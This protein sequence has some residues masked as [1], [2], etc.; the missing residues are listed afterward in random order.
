[1]RLDSG[2]NLLVGTTSTPTV[3]ISATS[4]G[5]IALDPDSYSAWNRE[6]TASNH[7][8]LVFNQ[9]GVD[10]QYLQFRKDGSIVGN[11]G[12][13][14]DRIYFAGA[15]EGIAIDDDLNALI[16]SEETGAARDNASDLGSSG[17]RWRNLYLG[18]G[19]YLGGT[20]SANLL[21]DYEEG[22]FYYGISLTISGSYTI[23]AGYETGRYTKIGNLVHIHLRYET[24]SQSS[25]SGDIK[26]TGL[27]FTAEGNPTDGNGSG[28]FPIL[29]RGDTRAG[30][31]GH[32]CGV[33]QSS[34]TVPLY[35]QSGTTFASLNAST[36]TGNFEGTISITYMTSQ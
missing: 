13:L 33:I 35:Y 16:P 32:F 28:Q 3:L 5:G 24:N 17:A 7:S 1:M 4:G 31:D 19:V 21:D 12:V 11:I 23:R 30:V 14:T 25:P 27:P 10:A 8:H 22:I 29:L 20:G 36:V 15:N 2:G 26:I 18:G 9:T 34:T 6:A